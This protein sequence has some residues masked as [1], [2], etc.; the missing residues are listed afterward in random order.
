M[1]LNLA[2]VHNVQNALAAIA[3]GREVGVRRRGDRARRS[4]S[5]TASAG[6]SSATARSRLADGG[7][8]TLIDDYGHHPVEMAATIAAA[9]G[10]FPGR[11]LVLAFQPHRYTRTRDLFE[12]FVSVLSTVDALVL[13][14]VY[15]AGEAPLVAAD[16]RALARALRVAGKVEPVFVESVADVP[17][18]SRR[19]AA[20][21]R[22]RRDHGCRVD[23]P[24]ARAAGWRTPHDDD[25]AASLR[26]LRG[27]LTRDASLRALH[28]LALRRPRRPRC[29]CRPIAPTWRRSSR[30]LP[31]D[32]PLTVIGLGSNL[33][34][35][36][37]GVRG[38]VVVLHAALGALAL[39]DGLIYAEAGVASPKVARFAA[40]HDRAGAEFLAGI[41][42]TVG[43]ALA[44]NAGCYGGETWRFVARV[45]VLQRD[46]SFVAARPRGVSDRV[47]LGPPRRRQRARRR[48]HRGL[49]RVPARRR[50]RGARSGSRSCC[51]A[52]STSQP[53]N[54][55][56]AGSVFRNP[57]GDHAARLIESCGLKGHAI[58]GARVSEK[59]ANFIVNPG[60]AGTAADIE[61]LIEHVAVQRPVRG[62]SPACELEAARCGSIGESRATVP[63][64]VREG[65]RTSG[66]RI[67]Q[68]GGADGRP[69]RRARD[70]AAVRQRGAGGAA[71]R[72]ASTR[73]RSTRPSATCGRSRPRASRACSSRCTAASARTAPC[74]ARSRCWAFPTPAAA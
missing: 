28:E 5:S 64:A 69:Q 25:R 38:T 27:T 19:A 33:L 48:L 45:E 51:N 72:E 34:V 54:L 56:N 73:T 39:R 4:P 44:M 41:P 66:E 70:L 30:E 22:R 12:D 11:R 32:E 9:R 6:G 63:R 36:D 57:D 74:R 24:G 53:L 50:P 52:G 46:G 42:G 68:S 10:S 15:P 17:A 31:A 18:R 59:H 61:A 21:R 14:D 29:T 49:V 37:G 65:E 60:G 71:R 23:R 1:E 20:R 62:R 13:A 7:S 26:A 40:L 3:V 2:G 35:R 58:G 47:P 55:P 43:G 16:G 8:F 67:R